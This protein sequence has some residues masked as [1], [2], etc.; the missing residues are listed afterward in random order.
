[1]GTNQYF[2]HQDNPGEQDLMDELTREIIQI[3]GIDMFYIPRD[4]SDDPLLRD[5]I[6]GDDFIGGFSKKYAIEMYLQN[7]D[8]MEG[9]GDLLAKFGVIIRDSATLV[10]SRSRF[11]EATPNTAPKEGD[12]I[13]YP[14]TKSLFEVTYVNFDNPFYQFGKLYTFTINI[15]LFQFSEETFD[16]GLYEVD[17]IPRERSYTTFFDLQ[18]GGVGEFADDESI[19][20]SGSSFGG[21]VSDFVEDEL[22]LKVI[23]SSGAEA[24]T[25]GYIIGL[26]SGASWGISYGDSFLMSNEGFADNKYFEDNKS[27]I[28]DTEDDWPFGEF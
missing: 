1:M 17:N 4:S 24:P 14:R 2:Q 23:Y 26:S 19:I 9:E 6:F 11:S 25:S 27:D 18:S 10:C 20:V 3:H 7:A 8:G 22:L 15:Q 5:E 16:V 13:W 21:S 12:L 28:I